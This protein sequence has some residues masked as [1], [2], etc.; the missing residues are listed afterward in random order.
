MSRARKSPSRAR[1]RKGLWLIAIFK[2]AKGLILLAV[3]IG[4][5]S[6]L[7]EDVATRVAGW[8]EAW[9]VDP[10][11]HFIHLLIRKL[12]SVDDAQLI[13]L[14]VGTF[15]YAALMLTEGV[16][17]ALHKRWAEYFTVF[18][19]SSFVPLEVYELVQAFSVVKVLVIIVNLAIVAYLII[20]LRKK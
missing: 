19:T 11:N 13:K 2:L 8:L 9:R 7:H 3:G 20:G 5:L 12:W 16:G 14:S 1:P 4:A 17:L 18:A 10:K 6:L 15:F